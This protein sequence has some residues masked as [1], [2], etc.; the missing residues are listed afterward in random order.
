MSWRRAMPMRSITGVLLA[1]WL[2]VGPSAFPLERARAQ[3]NVPGGRIAFVQDG[4]VRVWTPAGVDSLTSINDASDPTWSPA[5]DQVLY[6]QAGA[7]FSNLV[8]HNIADGRAFRVTDNQPYISAGSSDYVAT[9]S[10]AFDPCWSPAGAIAFVSDKGTTDHLM[11][12]W[13]MDS[14]RDEPYFAPYDGGDAGGIEQ[15]VLNARGDLAAYTVLAA[16]GELG[17]ITYVAVRD[18]ITGATT[19]VAEGPL[20]AYDPAISPDDGHVVVSIRTLAGVSDLWSVNLE[21]GE[22]NQL[23][24][25]Q[26]A[27]AAVFSP[28]GEWVA[29]MSPNDRSF[30]I[31]A[32]RINPDRSAL[33]SKPVRLVEAD[34]IDAT[35]GLSWID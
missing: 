10:W 6:V 15:V 28:D 17:G 3:G 20:G 8:I 30:D 5:G 4:N 18:L 16:G 35:S 33:T 13:L 21:S 1:A 2:V 26:Q 25:G 23:T 31:R 29:W 11:Q 19:P 12:L 7:S 24:T 9:S 34:G 14:I 22:E 32:A 27:T